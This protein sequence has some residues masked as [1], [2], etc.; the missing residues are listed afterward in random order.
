[1]GNLLVNRLRRGGFRSVVIVAVDAAE[2]VPIVHAESVQQRMVHA[3]KLDPLIP[4]QQSDV[5]A[6][7]HHRSEIGASQPAAE[8]PKFETSETAVHLGMEADD[9]DIGIGQRGAVVE[10]FGVIVLH[11]EVHRPRNLAG[12]RRVKR[13]DAVAACAVAE[14]HRVGKDVILRLHDLE[15]V[16]FGEK[17]DSKEIFGFVFA[18]F[19]Q[20]RQVT[21]QRGAVAQNHHRLRR[22]ADR[23]GTPD[24][25]AE[26]LLDCHHGEIQRRVERV[27]DES[28]EFLGCGHSALFVN[29]RPEREER[30]GSGG[31]DSARIG[32]AGFSPEGRLKS[33]AHPLIICKCSKRSV[34]SQ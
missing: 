9:A 32:P 10:A 25:V 30:N 31:R 14:E 8:K 13:P 24:V 12:E 6:D 7:L 15:A 19:D 4:Q 1:M 16:V 23:S 29:S 3:V 22:P 28:D 18:A 33:A 26:I 27:A 2:P 21:G 20:P 11:V 5:F 17:I 34:S